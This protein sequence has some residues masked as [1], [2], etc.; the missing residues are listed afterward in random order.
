MPGLGQH[1]TTSQTLAQKQV[2][3]QKMIQSI[4]LMAMPMVELREAI[5]QE[6]EKNPALE[7]AREA[8]DVV[9]PPESAV[10]SSL[11]ERD[12]FANSSD[13]GYQPSFSGDPDS[14]Q[15]FLEGAISRAPSLQDRLVEELRISETNSILISLGER[16]IWNL[17]RNG[18]HQENPQTLLNEG[19]ES[20]LPLALEHVQNLHPIG[21]ACQ[22]WQ[23]SILVQARIRGDAPEGFER[24]VLDALPLM[25]K[26]KP[27]EV[28][29][30]LK[31]RK[32]DWEELLEYI[33]LLNPFPGRQYSEDHAD[34]VI[35]DLEVRRIEG[36][37]VLTL[38]DEVLPVLRVDAE[39]EALKDEASGD[40]EA[41][42]FITDHAREAR[43]FINS[44]AQRDNT[45]LK[46][47][48]AI[49]DF[50]RDFFVG[51]PRHLRPLTLKDVA[52]EIEVHEATVSR[53]TTSKYM[54]TDW[55][56]FSLK[57]F[58]SNSISGAGSNG[59]QVSKV[60]AKEVIKEILEE[61]GTH[62]RIS[63]QKMS[64]LLA[65]RGINL[66]RRTVAKYRKELDLP[67]SYHR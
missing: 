3:T 10:P 60:A 59:S 57:Y 20:F 27:D 38:N 30:K 41:K 5:R 33:P 17:D 21:C 40:K 66:A 24:F 42:K 35:P 44:L 22:N 61:A 64:D 4:K 8:G 6:I 16:I 34:Y 47:A 14:K 67:S 23:E 54:Q 25:E 51:G 36:E 13:P 29:S 43:Y 32:E 50:Q 39:F 52:N 15:R 56:L 63:D 28:R 18:F 58:F 19:E 2:I 46:T 7:V 11:S 49:I 65:K 31:F 9:A 55:G 37:F 45:L 62:K 1:F 53:I 48:K 26:G 12:P